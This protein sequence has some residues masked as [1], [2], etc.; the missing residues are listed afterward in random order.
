VVDGD[1]VP[2]PGTAVVAADAEVGKVTSAAWS[3][4]LERP[5][6]LAMIRRQ[7]AGAGTALALR[8]GDATIPVTVSDLPVQTPSR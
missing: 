1:G 3:Y 4:A 7:H 8:V 2:D 5:I 6:A